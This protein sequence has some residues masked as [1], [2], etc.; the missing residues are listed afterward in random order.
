MKTS[1]TI[2]TTTDIELRA[3]DPGRDLPAVAEMIGDVN[4]HDGVP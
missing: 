2:G 4:D 3:L 1:T